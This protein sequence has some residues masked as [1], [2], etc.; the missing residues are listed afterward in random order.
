MRYK[1]HT[2]KRILLAALVLLLFPSTG[3]ADGVLSVPETFQEHREWC[4]A[5]S[6][7]AVLDYY[8]S[9]STNCGAVVT[10]CTIANWAWSRSDCCGNSDFNW[11]HTCNQSNAMYGTSGSLEAILVNWS[12]PTTHQASVLAQSEVRTEIDGA[13]PFVMRFGWTSGGGHFLV[14]RGIQGSNLYYMDPWPGNGYTISTYSWVVSASGHTW[15]HTL[16]TSCSQSSCYVQEVIGSNIN[17]SFWPPSWTTRIVGAP[18]N[19]LVSLGSGGYINVKMSRAIINGIGN[20][21]KVYECG[22]SLG[23]TSEAYHVY[24][25]SNCNSPTWTYIGSGSDVTS[26]DLSSTG[27]SSVPCLKLVD[28]GTAGGKMTGADFDT[29]EGLNASSSSGMVVKIDGTTVTISVAPVPGA[30]SYTLV[31]A[32]TD[33][34]Y[35][36]EYDMGNGSSVSFDLWNGAAFYV[37]VEANMNDGTSI[38]SEF[39]SFHI[40]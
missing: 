20:D 26:F 34:S 7:K 29:I 11:N 28:A 25:T 40:P 15:T 8:S 27:L 21:F 13:R 38:S 10:Q 36:G 24:G 2:S 23:G 33:L 32:P 31:Y 22:S 5:G 30:E 12:V 37:A 17:L 16:T 6:S 19:V 39:E 18:D 3:F 14:G 1:V 9:A 35:T 4:W